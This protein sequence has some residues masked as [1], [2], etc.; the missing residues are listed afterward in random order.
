M[1]GT[2][3]WIAAGL[4]HLARPGDVAL[5]SGA[6]RS[7]VRRAVWAMG[8][9]GLAAVALGWAACQEL[10]GLGLLDGS[11]QVS[12]PALEQW[13]LA[14]ARAN[15]LHVATLVAAAVAVLAWL[16]RLVDNTPR[17]GGGQPSVTP[18]WAILCWFV[19][20]ASQF[21]PYQVTADLWR[22]LASGRAEAAVG[23]VRAWWILWVVGG[24][25][26]YAIVWLP[27][28]TNLADA[29]L[30]LE[31]DALALGLQAIAGVLLVV[32]IRELE[33]RALARLEPTLAGYRRGT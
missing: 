24:I 22:R 29:R 33:R 28:P 18:R 8:F 9:V 21:K 17:L 5:P 2:N 30:Q 6:P 20:I 13:Q 3:G 1:A 32:V 10:S 15:V 14:V 27:A 19:P 26:D 11:S 4:N 25:A 23:L 31:A 16:S 7:S 12:L